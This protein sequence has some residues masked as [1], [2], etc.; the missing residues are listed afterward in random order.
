MNGKHGRVLTLTDG[1][2]VPYVTSGAYADVFIDVQTAKVYKAFISEPAGGMRDTPKATL[3]AIRSENFKTQVDAYN[4]VAS[5]EFLA[6]HTPQFL[7]LAAVAS[8][9]DAAKRDVSVE[10][11]LPCCYIVECLEGK[12]EKLNPRADDAPDHIKVFVQR[13]TGLGIGYLHDASVFNRSDAQRFRVIDF[14]TREIEM[15]W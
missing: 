1:S 5:D 6:S 12:D 10:Y 11:L 8:V 15:P 4:I 7:G 2:Q 13:C 14:G 9:H 3:D